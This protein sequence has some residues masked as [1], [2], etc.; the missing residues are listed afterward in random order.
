MPEEANEIKNYILSLADNVPETLEVFMLG[1][2]LGTHIGPY[3][4]GMG[5]IGQWDE[6][7]FS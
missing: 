4:I 7:W 6:K 3:C 2:V 5:W 1:P